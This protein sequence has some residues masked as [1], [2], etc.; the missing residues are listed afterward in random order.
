MKGKHGT[1]VAAHAKEKA[2]SAL[3]SLRLAE[4]ALGDCNRKI[5]SLEREV[6]QLKD[7]L[8][9][10]RQEHTKV[11]TYTEADV[12]QMKVVS[13]EKHRAAIRAGWAVFGPDFRFPAHQRDLLAEA[14][15][16]HAS[17]FFSGVRT[18]RITP[19]LSPS[20]TKI[21]AYAFQGHRDSS[22][23]VNN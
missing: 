3:E 23:S 4:I 15:E 20:N 13:E 18:S 19:R 12:A 5:A 22:W 1:K 6:E 16:C 11:G 17:D 7:S 2:A 14:F 21:A 9:Q 10:S 8:V